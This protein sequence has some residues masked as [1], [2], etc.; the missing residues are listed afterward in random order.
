M[1]RNRNT[2]SEHDA[3]R[4]HEVDGHAHATGTDVATSRPPA[5][6][7]VGGPSIIESDEDARDYTQIDSDADGQPI[8]VLTEL[9]CVLEPSRKA[10][11]LCRSGSLDEGHLVELP[12]SAFAA[13]TLID[14][15]EI[16]QTQ[17]TPTPGSCGVSVDEQ[18]SPLLLQSNRNGEE[19]HFYRPVEPL[20]GVLAACAQ[21]FGSVAKGFASMPTE[22]SKQAPSPPYPDAIAA[23]DHADQTP[24]HSKDKQRP[25]RY[26]SA[27]SLGVGKT[28]G[29]VTLGAVRLPFLMTLNVA[30][31]F[32]NLPALYKDPTYR[33]PEHITDTRSG[34]V[35]AGKAFAFGLYDGL[36]GVFTQPYTEV[37][38]GKGAGK[39][40]A[41]FCKGLGMGIAGLAFKPTAGYYGLVGY[42][43]EGIEKDIR[44]W[45][46]RTRSERGDQGL[47][48]MGTL[49]TAQQVLEDARPEFE[50][51]SPDV[52]RVLVKS[53]R[54]L[55]GRNQ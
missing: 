51:T 23:P 18:A 17:L 49:V 2:T 35:S 10:T 14:A 9:P 46:S 33:T 16:S 50:K 31:G 39:K 8:N 29:Y 28:V 20:T 40:A 41:G 4:E 44:K 43:Y 48:K 5:Y 30:R 1:M 52:R 21:A 13:M 27:A 36:T 7:S 34:A 19:Y 38:K 3:P 15:G 22:V 54:E 6:S 37:A 55:Q 32:D 47:I 25:Y 53:W 26:A 24:N 12:L 11:L 45:S 42:T